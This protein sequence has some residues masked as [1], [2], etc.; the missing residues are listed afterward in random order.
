MTDSKSEQ[1][2]RGAVT[3]AAQMKTLH[4]ESPLQ[5]KL[6][7]RGMTGA[8]KKAKMKD[9]A[10]LVTGVTNPQYREIHPSDFSSL[11]LPDYQRAIQPDEVNELL[12]VLLAGGV[13]ADPITLSRRKWSDPNNRPGKYYIVDG[14]QRA[15]ASMEAGKT[16]RAIIYDCASLDAERQ[17]FVVMNTQRVVGANNIVAAANNRVAA[18]LREVNENPD[19]PCYDRVVFKTAPGHGT[20][21]MGA[22]ILLRGLSLA[23]NTSSHSRGLTAQK[24]MPILDSRFNRERVDGYLRLIAEA[25]P[26]GIDHRLRLL[27][28]MA[29]GKVFAEKYEQYGRSV[30][31]SKASFVNLRRINWSKV[32]MGTYST[33]FLPVV[34]EA[35]RERWKA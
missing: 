22:S 1:V 14:Q 7:G 31:P 27:T 28:A 5:A 35:V 9:P 8:T 17:L 21:N 11:E 23:L 15:L 24:L 26:P 2:K 13:I 20:R 33:K 29:Y 25:T 34:L 3:K 18:F 4:R 32:T 12:R 30:M 16:I 19:H 10:L 6:R